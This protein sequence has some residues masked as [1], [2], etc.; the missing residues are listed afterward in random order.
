MLCDIKVGLSCNNACVHC[1]MEPVKKAQQRSGN[2]LDADTASV[3]ELITSAAERGFSHITLT[4][5]EV[6]VRPDFPELVLFALAQGLTVVVQTN[7]RQLARPN[8]RDFLRQVTD[9]A[10]VQFVIALH[11]PE[12]A[13][14]DAVTRRPGSFRQTIRGIESLRQDGFRVCGKLVIFRINLSGIVA[15]LRLLKCLDVDEGVVAFPHAEDFPSQIFHQVVPRYD[16]VAAVIQAILAADAATFPLAIS[17]ETI[18]YCVVR[19]V[20]F[21]RSSL[22]LVFLQERLRGSETLIEMSMTGDTID[23]SAARG[24]IKTK[25]AACGH[26]LLDPLC[27]GPWLEYVAHFGEGE[28][29]PV[30]DRALVN[31]FIE[32]I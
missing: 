23:W 9:P 24:Q 1:I 25:P 2:G 19:D 16:A 18:P 27:E 10:R 11:G 14:H 28:F 22:D 29:Q 32:A 20:R 26:C 13:I 12:E 15:T 3:K 8:R 31:Q 6:T 30:T 17:Y 21:W 5:G 4:G 7:G